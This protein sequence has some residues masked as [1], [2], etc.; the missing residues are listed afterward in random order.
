[1]KFLS[2]HYFFTATDIVTRTL[3]PSMDIESFIDRHQ[4]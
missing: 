4:L 2:F 3:P 1:M